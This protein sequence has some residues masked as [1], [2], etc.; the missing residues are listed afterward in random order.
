MPDTRHASLVN[1]QTHTSLLIDFNVNEFLVIDSILY[2]RQ[3]FKSSSSSSSSTTDSN[4]IP[5]NS[6]TTPNE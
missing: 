6:I 5:N 4:K 2:Q 1:K 3:H